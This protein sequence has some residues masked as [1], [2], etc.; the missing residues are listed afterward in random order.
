[1]LGSTDADEHVPVD[2]VEPPDEDPFDVERAC[3]R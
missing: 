2:D 3:S 1:L